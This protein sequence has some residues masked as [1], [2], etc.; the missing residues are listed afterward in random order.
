MNERW[1]RRRYPHMR[2]YES[3]IWTAFLGQTELEFTDVTYDLHLGVGVPT[4]PHDPPWMERLTRAITRKRVDVVA[5]TATDRW[6]FELKE[7]IG[8]SALGQLL[9]YAELYQTEYYL[10]VPLL[11]GAVGWRIAPDIEGTFDLHAI[12]IFIVYP[13]P[14]APAEQASMY[15]PYGHYQ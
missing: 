15:H 12:N 6:I 9:T 2:A 5:S 3:Q 13:Q 1:V 14:L 10:D 7:R 4:L 11:L 8:L